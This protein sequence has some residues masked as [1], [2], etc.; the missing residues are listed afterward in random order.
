MNIKELNEYQRTLVLVCGADAINM[1][2]T[3]KTDIDGWFEYA[4]TMTVYD[5]I[6]AAKAYKKYLK[7]SLIPE[8][9]KRMREY[10]RTEE[11][12]MGV[13]DY[14]YWYGIKEKALD[15]TIPAIDRY[16]KKWSKEA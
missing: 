6:E 2:K 9:D 14:D 11:K 5:C 13:Y 7:E 10:C 8:C 12:Y 15:T 4:K 3:N 1:Y 16:I